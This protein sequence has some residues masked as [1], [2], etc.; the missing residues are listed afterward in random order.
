VCVTGGEPLAQ[1][2]CLDL[3]KALCDADYQV[4]LETS[5]ACDIRLVD[6]RVMII[7]DLKTPDSSEPASYTLALNADPLGALARTGG[8]ER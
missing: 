7:M 3:L 2:A 6:K 5:G 8:L 4:S 1:P